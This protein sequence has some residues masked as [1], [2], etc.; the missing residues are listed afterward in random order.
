MADRT[1]RE[2]TDRTGDTIQKTTEVSDTDRQRARTANLIDRIVWLIAGIIILILAF[3]FV[4][5]LLGAN[6]DNG[7]AE[8]IYGLSYPF[9][10]PFFTLFSYDDTI[11]RTSTFELYTL[12][13]IGVY[14][15]LAWVI[16]RVLTLNRTA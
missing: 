5:S 12:I 9:V 16:S 3:R 15:V 11:T 2:T 6:R 10:A 14:A 8:F 4:L 13:A 1:V 7:F